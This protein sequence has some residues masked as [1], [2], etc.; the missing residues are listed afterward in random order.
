MKKI[1]EL[2]YFGTKKMKNVYMFFLQISFFILPLKANYTVVLT[3]VDEAAEAEPTAAISIFIYLILL[4]NNK[5]ALL[6]LRAL[7]LLFK[8]LM[9]K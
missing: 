7:L 1:Y 5:E 6:Q 2:R 4:Y 9:Y 3:V 8:H